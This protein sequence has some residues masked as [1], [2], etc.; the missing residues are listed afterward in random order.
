[1]S[2]PRVGTFAWQDER[3]SAYAIFNTNYS[4]RG[5]RLTTSPQPWLVVSP[6]GGCERFST[7]SEAITYAVKAAR[8]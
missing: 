1:M 7:H 8:A 4:P 5:A 3:S 2:T 6:E